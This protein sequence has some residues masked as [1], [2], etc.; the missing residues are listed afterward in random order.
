MGNH[1]FPNPFTIKYIGPPC[2]FPAES[3]PRYIT[4]NAEVKNFVDIPIIPLTHIQNI[5]PGPPIEIATATPA[6]LP[7]PTVAESAVVRA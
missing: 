2:F 7:I 5:A 1:F 6:I 3:T 4:A